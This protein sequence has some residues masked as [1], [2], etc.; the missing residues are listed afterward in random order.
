[1]M[2]YDSG[3]EVIAVVGGGTLDEEEANASAADSS[4]RSAI[5]N[6]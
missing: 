3:G 5:F 4:P 6:N 1:M 2:R